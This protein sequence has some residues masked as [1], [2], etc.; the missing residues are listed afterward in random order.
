MIKDDEGRHTM[1]FQLRAPKKAL[2]V[3][4]TML[5]AISTLPFGP[6]QAA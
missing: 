3:R 2:M 1:D 6:K 4:P 5:T